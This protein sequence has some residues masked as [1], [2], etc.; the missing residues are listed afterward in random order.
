MNNK[1][2]KNSIKVKNLCKSYGKLKAV[3]NIS[4]QV[5]EGEIFGFLGPNGAGKTTT[6]RM[7]TGVFPPDSG[8][9]YINGYDL[10]K[11]TL[12]AKMKMGVVPELANAYLDLT[13]KQNI[14]FIAEMYGLSGRVIEKRAD[15][16]L[17]KFGLAKRKNDKIKQFSKGMKQRVVICMSLINSPEILFLDEPTSGLDVQSTRLIR[18]VIRDLNGKGTTIFLT[19]H[20]IE[21]ANTLCDRIAIMKKGSIAAIDSPE[22]LKKIFKKSQSVEVNFNNQIKGLKEL[23]QNLDYVENVKKRG[24]KFNLQTEKPGKVVEGM[25][26]LSSQNKLELNSVK[27]IGPELAEVFIRLTGGEVDHE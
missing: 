3:D 2:K 12:Q 24:D 10:L 13:A 7:I 4:F 8:E 11:K 25:V 19:T 23:L 16:L 5:W 6:T 1:R 20:N 9:I 14:M 15:E 22:N 27:T 21:E 17:I 26:N 18:R